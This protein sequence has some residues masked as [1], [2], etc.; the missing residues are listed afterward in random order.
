VDSWLRDP[1]GGIV[2]FGHLHEGLAHLD[3]DD[4]GITSDSIVLPDG[5]SIAVKYNQEITSIRGFVPGTWVFNL[6]MYRKTDLEP[7]TVIVKVEKLNPTVKLIY[8]KEV[9]LS[10][11]GEE[12]TILSFDTDIH[13]NVLAVDTNSF[14]DLVNQKLLQVHHGVESY[15]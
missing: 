9:T 13:G 3:R 5:T 4:L 6:H 12:V 8:R 1:A 10:K 15:M 11:T 2:W 7:V 14:V